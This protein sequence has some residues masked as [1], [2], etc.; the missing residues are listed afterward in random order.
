MKA[1]QLLEALEAAAQK[2]AIRI[3]Y[4]SLGA[5]GVGSGGGLCKVRGEWW[6]MLDKKLT[7]AEKAALIMETLADFDTSELDLPEKARAT[8]DARRTL[9]ATTTGIPPVA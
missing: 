5:S 8:I 9:K 6:L 2:L 4:E 7:A 3:R 1:E